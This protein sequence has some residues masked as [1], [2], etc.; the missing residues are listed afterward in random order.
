MFS[1]EVAIRFI[2]K[3]DR[4][5]AE[6]VYEQQDNN[7]PTWQQL[8]LMYGYRRTMNGEDVCP[9]CFKEYMKT[10]G[11]ENNAEIDK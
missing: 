8:M 3:C 11:G 9:N 4:C 5:G 7:P 1:K 6:R 10:I 2:C